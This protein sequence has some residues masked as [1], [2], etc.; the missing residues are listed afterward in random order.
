MQKIIPQKDLFPNLIKLDN[1]STALT[2]PIGSDMRAVLDYSEAAA[3]KLIELFPGDN[4]ALIVRGMSGAII[5]GIIASHLMHNANICSK[6][7][8][9]RKPEDNCHAS[10]LEDLNS[11]LNYEE[12]NP[13]RLVIA[14]DFMCTGSTI[15]N[16]VEDVESYIKQPFIFDALIVHNKF[17][18]DEGDNEGASSNLMLFNENSITD[19]ILLTKFL[20]ILCYYKSTK[21][22]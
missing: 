17:I 8:I 15:C 19:E 5:G 13:F 6:I 7:I 14:D 4:I 12:D 3:N 9:S 10:N 21:S 16:I 2:Y 18:Y 22:Y 1:C 20:N 11:V